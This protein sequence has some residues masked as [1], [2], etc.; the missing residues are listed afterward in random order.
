MKEEIIIFGYSGH[1]F[2]VVDSVSSNTNQSIVG[3][4]DVKENSLDPFALTYFGSEENPETLETLKNTSVFPAVGS[5]KVRNRLVN[6]FRLHNLTETK[7]IHPSSI[8]SKT[9]II[10]DSTFINAG[11]ILN[12]LSKI[13]S[14]CIINS[15]AIIEHECNIGDFCHIAPGAV[16]CGNVN[17]GKNVFIGANSVVKQGVIIGDDAVVGAGSTVLENIPANETWFGTPAQKKT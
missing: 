15:G 4:V 16:L 9:S 14:G 1:S 3:Y 10:G 13:G 5:N 8:V 11:V 7:I 2:T 17:L 12:A 6:F